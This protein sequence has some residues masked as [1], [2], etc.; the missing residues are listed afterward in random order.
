[1]RVDSNT[2]PNLLKQEIAFIR[3]YLNT[4][5]YTLVL[6]LHAYV[7][8]AQSWFLLRFFKVNSV[9]ILQAFLELGL[10]VKVKP[11]LNQMKIRI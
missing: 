5:W 8:S 4:I 9:H 2:V 6:S 1:M 11:L 7:I 3:A 10:H